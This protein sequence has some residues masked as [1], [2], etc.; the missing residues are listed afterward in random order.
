MYSE[1]KKIAQ[2]YLKVQ[3]DEENVP[4][5]LEW[6]SDDNPHSSEFQ[7]VKSLFLSMLDP[8]TFD[9]L[10]I[11]LWTKKLEVQEMDRFVYQTIRSMADTYQKATGN[12]GL[13]NEM[14]K[15]AQFFGEST[16]IINHE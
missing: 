3:L 10:K 6:R 2:I 15:F 13:A 5:K 14:Q 1:V 11:D 12:T 16:K 7:E 9:T 4:V 8:E